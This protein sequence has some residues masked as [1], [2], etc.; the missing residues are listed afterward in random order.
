M[1]ALPTA[2]ALVPARGGSK[3]I[4]LKNLVPVAGVPLMSYGIW[5]AQHSGVLQR[6]VCSTESPP[7][8]DLARRHG[9]EIDHRPA[10]LCGDD[11]AVAD[12]A[13]E[14]LARQTVPLPELLVLVQPTSPFLQP[15]H[16][17]ALLAAMA[18]DPQAQ[19]GHNVTQ[20][21]H[22]FHVW[23]SRE[24]ADGRVRFVFAEQRAAG[25]NKQRKPKSFYFG[26]LVAARTAALLRGEGFFA[27]PMATVEIAYPF[28]FDLDRADDI[29]LAEALIERNL[30]R[31]FIPPRESAS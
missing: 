16:V 12:V 26:N 5:A 19:S 6:I 25:Y 29:P 21:P 24:V 13:A 14:F 27:A 20:A 18:A 31:P 7:I 10:D 23:N 22:N 1:T 28:N 4:P 2:W 15:D 8:A 11:T 3:S 30:A 9:I 17:R